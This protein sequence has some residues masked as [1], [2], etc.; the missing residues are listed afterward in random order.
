MRRV[1]FFVQLLT[2]TSVFPVYADVLV[3]VANNFYLPSQ[4]LAEKFE[5]D[6]GEKIE[7]STGSTGQLYAQIKNG[8][9]F[10]IFLAADQARPK[11]LA[12]EGLS[13]E[14]KTYAQG[15]LVLWSPD[16]LLIDKEGAVLD[17]QQYAY[18]AV[19]DPKLAPYGA[20]AMEALDHIGLRE[21]VTA[22]QVVGKGLNATYQYVDSG[23]AQLGFLA[24]SQVIDKIKAKQGSFWKVPTSNYQPI[25]QDAV[26]MKAA[27]NKVSA[28]AFMDYLQ[29]EAGR[30]LIADYGYEVP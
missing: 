30:Q 1:V 12:D 7:I 6:T 29:S 23:N 4:K 24:Y 9:P 3:A 15:I 16:P 5:Q 28:V 2:L 18:I 17:S 10:D 22:K 27:A 21:V 20:A 26:L 25:L 19:A 8:A 14:A 11:A 13:L